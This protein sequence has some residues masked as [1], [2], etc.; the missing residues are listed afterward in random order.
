M[1]PRA[2]FPLVTL[3]A[4]GA[5][6]VVFGF[7]PGSAS[8]QGA[9]GDLHDSREWLVAGAVLALPPELREGAEVRVRTGGPD[10][11]TIREGTNGMICLADEP[12]GEFQVACYHE[13]LEPFM[14]RGRELG[15]EG[16]QGMER[17]ERRWEDVEAGR[18]PV[19]ERPTMV[20]NL[21]FET[22]AIDPD[23]VDWKTGSRLHAAYI[24]YATPEETGLPTEP[25]Q[26][27]P[28]LMWPGKPSAHIMVVI[29]P[30]SGGG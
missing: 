14:R 17:Q 16:Y 18:V 27:E 19:P 15:A 30:S 5:A 3:L 22:E 29:P 12:G 26:G 9:G 1:R 21:G 24:P 10:L 13:D 8:A 6:A 11:E 25:S 20:Y 23:T 28:W 7:L 2:Q 4:G